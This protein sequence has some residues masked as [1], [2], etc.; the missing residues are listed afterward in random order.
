MRAS[1][2]AAAAGAAWLGAL[3]A[4]GVASAHLRTGTVAVGYA[5]TV[6][7][8]A[9]PAFT[10]QIY[11]SDLGVH[12]TVRPG[13][14]VV[15]LGYLGEPFLRVGPAGVAVD[16]AS[17]T[18]AATGLVARGTAGGWRLRPGRSATWHDGRVSRL[19]AGAT[20]ARWTIPLRVDGG[21]ATLG[22]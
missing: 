20:S 3:L 22:G 10:A 13:H 4:P 15:V 16:G 5:A 12:L 21:R 11:R 19:R 18:A 7:S 14:T 1:R 17:P 8:P 2:I 9:S 6:T